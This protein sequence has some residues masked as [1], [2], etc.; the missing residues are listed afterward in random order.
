MTKDPMKKY[1]IDEEWWRWQNLREHLARLFV[2]PLVGH[3]R[4][5]K[6]GGTVLC[7]RCNTS[8]TP[9]RGKP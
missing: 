9:T 4:L 8:P 5:T 6:F 2:C 7:R 1:A 3:D